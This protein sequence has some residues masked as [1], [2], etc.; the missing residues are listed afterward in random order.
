MKSNSQFLIAANYST[1]NVARVLRVFFCFG[2]I[3]DTLG[4]LVFD[5]E[6][7]SQSSNLRNGQFSSHLSVQVLQDFCRYC[8]N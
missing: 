1:C 8:R 7:R 2:D 6:F 3:M 4:Q 5:H